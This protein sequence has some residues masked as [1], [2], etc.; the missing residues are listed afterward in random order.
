MNILER[1][2]N[3]LKYEKNYSSHTIKAYISD[4]EQ[5]NN[6]LVLLRSDFISAKTS[7]LRSWI[8]NLIENKNSAT[9][10]HRKISSLKTLYSFLLREK[11]VLTDPTRKLILPKT[12]KRL[13]VFVEEKNMI[14]LFSVISFENNFEGTRNKLILSLLYATG[15]RLSELITLKIVDVDLEN[16]FIKVFGKRRKERII[17]FG[18]VLEN[19]IRQYLN[20]RKDFK[21]KFLIV[22]KKDEQSYP[23][24]IY[25][26]VHRYLNMITNIEK[27][28]PHVVRHTFATHLLNNG[29]DLNAIKELLGHANLAATQVYTHNSFEQL[30]KVYNKAHPRA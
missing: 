8:V 21:N 12:R 26:I 9:S 3:Y 19:D 4:L 13:P 17:P 18:E 2:S 25:R 27:K 6:F 22:T 7:D 30:K 1:F 20:K 24:M 5:C 29:A 15:I 16:K 23:E 14:D 11:L 10:I 28:S